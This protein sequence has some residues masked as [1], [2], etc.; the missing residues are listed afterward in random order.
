MLRIHL[1]FETPNCVFLQSLEKLSLPLEEEEEV[2]TA[3]MLTLGSVSNKVLK[4]NSL[5]RLL[6]SS[7]AVI[8]KIVSTLF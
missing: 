3:I 8:E 2:V 7:Y 4:N 1:C 5:S 6:S